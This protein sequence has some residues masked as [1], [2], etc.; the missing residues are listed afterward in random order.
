MRSAAAFRQ[1]GFEVRQSC[2]YLDPETNQGREID[3][4]ATDPDYLGVVEIHFVIE[5]KATKKPWVLLASD[6]TLTGFNRIFTFGVLT[7][8]AI[9]TFVKRL[10]EFMDTQVW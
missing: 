2:H 9:N 4:L 8:T 3:V 5:C 10:K 6:D 7:K 1:A